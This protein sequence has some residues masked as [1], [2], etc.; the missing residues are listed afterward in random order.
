MTVL[1]ARLRLFAGD[2]R[3]WR[4]AGRPRAE[5][6]RHALRWAFGRDSYFVNL[7]SWLH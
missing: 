1:R 3:I 4:N 5:A 7:A 6:I 2:Y